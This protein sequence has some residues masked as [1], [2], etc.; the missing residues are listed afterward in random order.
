MERPYR[1]SL[2]GIGMFECNGKSLRKSIVA[3]TLLTVVNNEIGSQIPGDVFENLAADLRL[4][5]KRRIQ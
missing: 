4:A 1:L 3:V 5:D 2:H